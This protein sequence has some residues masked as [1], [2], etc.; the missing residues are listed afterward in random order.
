MSLNGDQIQSYLYSTT[1]KYKDDTEDEIKYQVIKQF[2][3]ADGHFN[4]DPIQSFGGNTIYQQIL[5]IIDSSSI[6]ENYKSYEDFEYDMVKKILMYVD[7]DSQPIDPPQTVQIILKGVD[8]IKSVDLPLGN[9]FTALFNKLSTI[10]SGGMS[11]ILK[12]AVLIYFLYFMRYV[13]IDRLINLLGK[14]VEPSSM[15]QITQLI[16]RIVQIPTVLQASIRSQLESMVDKLLL[17]VRYE[18]V[19]PVVTHFLENNTGLPNQVVNQ[20]VDHAPTDT[21]QRLLY[22]IRFFNT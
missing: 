10:S 5:S 19:V 1:Q 17:L 9:L 20:L 14:F 22:W 3:I 7:T 4:G 8:E 16:E 12:L 11:T 21:V 15:L 6:S 18:P 13:S 2:L